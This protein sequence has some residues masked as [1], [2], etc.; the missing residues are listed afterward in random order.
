M[1]KFISVCL[2]ITVIMTLA[3]SA[4]AVVD[5][6]VYSPTG[7]PAP[8]LIDAYNETEECTAEVIITSFTNRGSLPTSEEAAFEGAYT[9]I[10]GS[11]KNLTKLCPSLGAAATQK[12]ASVEAL[13]VSDLFNL[14][15][16]DCEDHEGHGKFRIKLSADLLKH[17]V[18]LM[19]FDGTQWELVDSAKVD[20]TGEYLEFDSANLGSFAIVV[21]TESLPE[22]S[23]NTMLYI[24]GGVMLVSAIAFTVIWSKSRKETV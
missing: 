6:F 24:L 23:D 1:K 12:G 8:E 5:G 21:D 17:F 13:A 7:R 16:K 22:T 2:I 19:R 9:A 20:G 3:V 11:A 15:F 10:Q 14:S 4:F 18:G